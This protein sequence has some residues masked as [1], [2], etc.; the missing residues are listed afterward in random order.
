MIVLLKGHC[1]CLGFCLC[2]LVQFLCVFRSSLAWSLSQGQRYVDN[3]Y[4]RGPRL[5]ENLA[6]TEWRE[7]GY[8][9]GSDWECWKAVTRCVCVSV[10]VCLC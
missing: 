1:E 10:Y 4:N 3:P 9:T 7:L 5:T 2:M 8:E 6:Q